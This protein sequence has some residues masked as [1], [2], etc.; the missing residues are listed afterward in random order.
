MSARSRRGRMLALNSIDVGVTNSLSFSAGLDLRRD[1]WEARV[2]LPKRNQ[3][4]RRDSSNRTDPTER[5]GV[6]AALSRGLLD[7]RGYF[8]PL[9]ARPARPDV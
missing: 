8:R 6:R 1:L 2:T 7:S 5:G 4:F 3:S 9:H